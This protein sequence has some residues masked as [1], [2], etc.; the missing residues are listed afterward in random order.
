MCTAFIHRG[1]D[2]IC[3]YSLDLDPAVWNYSIVRKKDLFSV[4]IRI[5][6]T[7]YYTHGVNADGHFGNLPYMNGTDTGRRGVGPGRYRIDLLVDRYLRGRLSYTEVLDIANSKSVISGAGGSFH[8]LIGDGEG[9]MLLIEPSY[10]VREM[11][12]DYA[13]VS[14]FPVIPTLPD[15]SNP[16]YGKERYDAAV[17]ILAAAGADFDV[18]QGREL[19][20][21]VRQEGQWGTRLS[22]VYSR[23]ENAMSYWLNGDFAQGERWQLG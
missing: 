13:C 6:S 8:S 23:N 15:Y 1:N 20:R 17:G 18:A 2:L 9:H 3:G 19:L 14:N 4:A 16:F 12:G 21:A 7:T 22:F 11:R 5:G 10:G